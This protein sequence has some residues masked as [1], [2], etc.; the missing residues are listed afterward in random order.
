MKLEKNKIVL[1]LILYC[2]KTHEIIS[3]HSAK[4]IK[5]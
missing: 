3:L 1:E 2:N 5:M 4:L